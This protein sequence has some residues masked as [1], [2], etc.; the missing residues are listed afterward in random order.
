M[1]STTP[2]SITLKS[3]KEEDC[4]RI[5]APPPPPPVAY[6]K[7]APCWLLA[8]RI[9]EFRTVSA[10]PIVV[11]NVVGY[12]HSP[13]SFMC[14]YSVARGARHIA[15]CYDTVDLS[16][17]NRQT[18]TIKEY[19]IEIHEREIIARLFAPRFASHVGRANSHLSPATRR[20]LSTYHSHAVWLLYRI[21]SRSI[22]ASGI[23]Q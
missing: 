15:D 17:T 4:H 9:S 20:F 6:I 19:T 10:Q 7:R 12:R 21:D 13:C 11:L 2:P 22:S 8:N 16:E 3:V 14:L 5:K 1:T 18:R 23:S